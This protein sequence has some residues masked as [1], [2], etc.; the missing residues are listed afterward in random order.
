M[1]TD[2][3]LRQL[4]KRVADRRKPDYLIHPE[5][6]YIRRWWV[7]P[8]NRYFNIYLHRV[9]ANDDDRALHDHPWFCSSLILDGAYKEITPTGSTVRRKG[10]FVVRKGTALHRLE[11]EE[12][13]VWS[14]FITG[15]KYREWG[16]MDPELGWIH[17]SIYDPD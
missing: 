15:P 11:V 7:I 1:F 4:K 12:G 10:N 2:F 6:D 13:P 8:R 5:R 16:F 17:H 14:L 3:L 9:N